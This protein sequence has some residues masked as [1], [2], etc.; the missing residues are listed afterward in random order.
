MGHIDSISGKILYL[1]PS[2]AATVC[3]LLL[4]MLWSLSVH[5]GSFSEN[6]QFKIDGAMQFLDVEGDC[7][8]FAGRD[9]KH[10]YPINVSEEFKVDGI[11]VTA[12]IVFRRDIASIC[13]GEIVKISGIRR[14]VD[15]KGPPWIISRRE[16]KSR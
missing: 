1:S 10:Y 4:L 12:T 5:G 14:S 9:G 11:R 2:R 8:L 3:L 15:L 7:W 16:E 6:D 13:P